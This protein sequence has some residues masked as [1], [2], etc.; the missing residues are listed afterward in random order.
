MSGLLFFGSLYFVYR[1]WYILNTPEEVLVNKQ[2]T[3]ISGRAVNSV[4]IQFWEGQY[5]QRYIFQYQCATYLQSTPLQ[6]PTKTRKS[7]AQSSI[8]EYERV[9]ST[10]VIII[11][12]TLFIVFSNQAFP[13]GEQIDPVGIRY[14]GL[15]RV[16][17]LFL[18]CQFP[19]HPS[20][21]SSLPSR[22]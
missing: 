6:E 15:P 17:P 13:P 9:R 14:Y 7:C 21:I 18:C 1:D 16:A 2:L 5:F 20:P 4:R 19:P 11:N 22:L 8:D 3:L 12:K 10:A